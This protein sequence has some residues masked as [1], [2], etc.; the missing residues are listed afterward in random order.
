MSNYSF[1]SSII[2]LAADVFAT[3]IG[4]YRGKLFPSRKFISRIITR[5]ALCPCISS[6]E[7]RRCKSYRLFANIDILYRCPRVSSAG[8]LPAKRKTR[9]RLVAIRFRFDVASRFNL[10]RI[11]IFN[12]NGIGQIVRECHPGECR[13]AEIIR[14][15]IVQEWKYPA[16]KIAERSQRDCL[17]LSVRVRDL[18]HVRI[19]VAYRLPRYLDGVIRD[20]TLPRGWTGA[21]HARSFIP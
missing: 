20:D 9:R 15:G 19:R 2:H 6:L 12:Q 7:S 16:N 21:I 5:Y 17:R 1:F 13:V 18:I 8:D 4:T 14:R 10:H 11:S 3:E